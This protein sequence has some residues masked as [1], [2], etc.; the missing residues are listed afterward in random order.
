MT[1]DEIIST[2][3]MELG[4]PK[5]LVDNTYKAYW[6]E[7]RNHITSLPL[8]DNITDEEFR[9]LQPNV[10][11]PSIGKLYVTLDRYKGMN[12]SYR[13]NQQLKQERNVTRKEN[14][15]TV[16]SPACDR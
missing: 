3:S 15:A 12:K 5:E 16:Q 1:Y 11:I 4:L 14:Q 10:N 6:K 8:K 9:A 7:V 2:V 13:I